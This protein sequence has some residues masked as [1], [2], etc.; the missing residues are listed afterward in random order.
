MKKKTIWAHTLVKNEERYLWYAVMS[1]VDHVDKILLWDTG[2]SD[3]TLKIIEEIKKAKGDKIDFRE[4]G[5]VDPVEFTKVR[6]KMLDETKSDWFLIV[7]GDEV[8]WKDSIR[9][10]VE[11]IQKEGE[12]LE[13]IIS[14]YY[15]IIGDIYHYQEEAGG[16]YH[17]DDRFGH[18]NIR[19]VNRRIPGLH[20][21][22]PHGQQGFYDKEGVL[23]QERLP[24]YRKFL[25]ASYL[26]F[27]NMR[28]SFSAG[29]D[30]NV[31]KRKI[32]FKY[33]L[34]IPFPAGFKHPEVFYKNSPDIVSSPWQK[35]SGKYL[36]RAG[37][38]TVLK[39]I[40]R[41]ILPKKTVGY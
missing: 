21:E 7:D 25:D 36:L 34:G 33:E 35:M 17:I 16:G 20:L 22:K 38:E 32:K 6:Q 5:A 14:P 23:I 40:K 29:E 3:K 12:T 4:C 8:W 28:R 30:Q 15:N 24:K 31:P 2:S 39:K 27:T 13:T 41:R 26:H 11:T 10:V 37:A 18:I 1:V 9:L 19:A